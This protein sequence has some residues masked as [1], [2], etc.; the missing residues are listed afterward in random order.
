MNTKDQ[1][2]IKSLLF[3]SLCTIIAMLVTPIF[4]GSWFSVAQKNKEFTTI[5]SH[6]TDK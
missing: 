5:K 3:I 1:S 6:M 2:F 4:V